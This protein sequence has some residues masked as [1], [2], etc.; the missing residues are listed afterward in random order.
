MDTQQNFQQ[1]TP[2]EQFRTRSTKTD[3][4]RPSEFEPFLTK[5]QHTEQAS[6]QNMIQGVPGQMDAERLMQNVQKHQSDLSHMSPIE[7]L[8]RVPQSTTPNI[9]QFSAPD[10]NNKA[11]T[12]FPGDQATL[13]KTINKILDEN[14]TLKK[15]VEVCQKIIELFQA[16]GH[17]LPENVSL[18]P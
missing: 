8:H 16:S 13:L 12:G 18:K 10:V 4:E 1:E 17:P 5:L 9:S 6:H 14:T 15:H 7:N 2:E 3:L 11:N